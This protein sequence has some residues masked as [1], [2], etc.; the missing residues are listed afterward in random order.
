[1]DNDKIGKPTAP[2]GAKSA[3]GAISVRAAAPRARVKSGGEASAATKIQSPAPGAVAQGATCAPDPWIA[4]GAIIDESDIIDALSE[5]YRAYAEAVILDRA[6]PD[7]RDG[8]KP[9]QRRL[10]HL[11]HEDRYLWG[12]PFRK[13]ARIVGSLL[14]KYHPH[15]DTSVYNTLARF[16]QPWSLSEKLI[17]GQGNFGSPDGDPPA[18]MRYTEARLAPI[19]EYLVRDLHP[20]IVP[21]VPNYDGSEQEPTV[22][23]AE[24]PN[25]LVNGAAGIAVGVASSIPPHSLSEVI[26]ATIART[27]DA[28]CS[29]DDILRA[30]PAPDFPT[31][32][33]IT[34]P[35]AMKRIYET[36]KGAVIVEA[37]G[38]IEQTREGPRLVY[39]DMT[40]NLAKPDLLRRIN[41]MIGADPDGEIVSARDESGRQGVRFVV[42]LR[43]GADA[44]RAMR[45]LYRE[46]PLRSTF[47][48]SLTAI[49]LRGRPME[50][51]LLSILDGWI[52][53][54]LDIIRRR[55]R[56]DLRAAL[57]RGRILIGRLLA[58]G[59]IDRIVKL[60]R[61][62]ADRQAAMAALTTTPLPCAGH[63]DALVR[64]G[65]CPAGKVPRGGWRLTA[66]QAEDILALRLQRLTGLE[67]DALVKEVAETLSRID[68]QR[69]LLASDA[70][71]RALMIGEMEHIARRFPR[72]RRTIV[73]DNVAGLD[74]IAFGDEGGGAKGKGSRAGSDKDRAEDRTPTP[75]VRIAVL[76]DM[77]LRKVKDRERRSAEPGQ[78]L[79]TLPGDEILGVFTDSGEVHAIAVAD[80]GDDRPRAI[81]AIRGAGFAGEPLA[82]SGLR[83][84]PRDHVSVF[85][86]G[87][88]RRNGGDRLAALGRNRSR[89]WGPE[90]GKLVAALRIEAD[91][92]LVL[93]TKRG[94]A[95]RFACAEMRAMGSTGDSMGVAG[96]TL[97]DG[98]EIVAAIALK[99]AQEQAAGAKKARARKSG[100]NAGAATALLLIDDAG[101]AMTVDPATIK[102]ARRG[103]KGGMIGSRT[104]KPLGALISAIALSGYADGGP[105]GGP[106]G[107]PDSRP[108]SG[109][110]S[111]GPESGAQ[112]ADAAK[113]GD[114]AGAKSLRENDA[115]AQTPSAGHAALLMRG[116]EI[117]GAIDVMAL[118]EGR[119]APAGI[120]PKPGDRLVTA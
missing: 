12:T 21:F 68:E 24:F 28:D 108:D 53:F 72:A 20:E 39:T 87:K 60:I 103:A 62:S 89:R 85:A 57:R 50:T 10:L 65:L 82:M 78:S 46:T 64:L 47:S 70:R 27:R 25:L 86:S 38:A 18:A 48:V 120:A 8:M 32:G 6:L 111:G 66:E 114:L 88:V 101:M 104:K 19:S 106:D 2:A 11:M 115:I 102:T 83:H 109:P 117:V 29:L 26:A 55:A 34:N 7:L 71:Q 51:G 107:R 61:S 22:L 15:G 97:D 5:R 84:D 37:T 43:K 23:P 79:I 3:P 75:D 13:S 63:E 54:R 91:D 40:P 118:R 58:V 36:G 116:G 30:M 56:R 99:A 44:E 110:D 45:R 77:R 105:D 94:F 93:L 33:R 95:L 14:G 100:N 96:M 49:D 98:D 9:S 90:D 42:E 69:D 35:S 52:A 31:G 113:T 112:T 119:P 73:L 67:R 16:A 80:I 81:A 92:D 17:D 1:M 4:G 76:A 59:Q 74:A 41:D